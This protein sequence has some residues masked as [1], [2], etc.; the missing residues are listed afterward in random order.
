MVPA[1]RAR[2]Q[3]ALRLRPIVFLAALPLTFKCH[4][5]PL[6]RPTDLQTQRLGKMGIKHVDLH[7]S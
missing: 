4:R 3:D 7:A 6:A 1:V 2:M 5:S